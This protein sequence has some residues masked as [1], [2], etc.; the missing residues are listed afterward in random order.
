MSYLVNRDDSGLIVNCVDDPI[1]AL[2]NTV[3]I[4]I[5]GQFLGTIRARIVR[6]TANLPDDRRRSDFDP[7]A[8]NSFPAEGLMKRL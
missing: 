1:V 7:T 6:E 2:S 4:F 3:A 8:S 5:A